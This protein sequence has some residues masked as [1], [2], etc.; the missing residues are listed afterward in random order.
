MSRN[1][2]NPEVLQLAADVL[3]NLVSVD[4]TR[5]DKVEGL[6]VLRDGL[7]RRARAARVSALSSSSNSATADAEGAAGPV[8]EP[9]LM[10]SVGGWLL[11][12]G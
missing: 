5:V 8:A 11:D 6:R 3:G 12:D 9:S 7:Q 10:E 2:G 1:S 4:D